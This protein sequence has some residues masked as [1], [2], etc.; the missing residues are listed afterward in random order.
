MS[1][2]GQNQPLPTERHGVGQDDKRISSHRCAPEI[3]DPM[4]KTGRTRT[5]LAAVIGLSA[6]AL[7]RYDVRL[8]KSHAPFRPL[9]NNHGVVGLP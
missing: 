8:A 4:T 7:P 6:I 2:I 9:I 5:K 1:D 3:R